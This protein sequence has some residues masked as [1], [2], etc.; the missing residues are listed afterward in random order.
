MIETPIGMK[1]PW[2]TYSAISRRYTNDIRSFHI[3]TIVLKLVILYGIKI[4]V[5][6]SMPQTSIGD[7]SERFTGFYRRLAIALTAPF[8]FVLLRR[9]VNFQLSALCLQ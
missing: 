1:I 7:L 5:N 8:S 6:P 9:G 3:R 2:I 4:T